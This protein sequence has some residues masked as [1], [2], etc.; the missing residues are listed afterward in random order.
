MGGYLSVL[1]IMSPERSD[2]V[3][4]ADVPDGE[5]NVFVLNSFDVEAFNFVQQMV[6]SISLPIVGIVVTISPS[7][8]LYK[9][10]VLPAASRPTIKIRICFLA[11]SRFSKLLTVSP[12]LI[13]V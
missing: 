8:S 10:V 12:I 3:L 5:G 13:S 11:K 7:L 6:I 9:M 4:S 1:V 2:F